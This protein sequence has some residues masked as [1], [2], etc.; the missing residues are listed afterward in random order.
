MPRLNPEDFPEELRE[1]VEAANAEYDQAVEAASRYEG[2]DGDPEVLRRA[3]TMYDQY[4]DPVRAR[5]YR[6]QMARDWGI[7]QEGQSLDDLRALNE[8]VA[9][10]PGEPDPFYADGV[11]PD[12]QAAMQML[13]QRYLSR[14][15][16]EA[17]RKEMKEMM[18][19]AER[20]RRLE[21][22]GMALEAQERDLYRRLQAEGVTLSDTARQ[23][24]QAIAEHRLS[25]G[26]VD[27]NNFHTTIE[28]SYAM[29]QQVVA[30]QAA[31]L[32]RQQAAAPKVTDPASQT[33]GAQREIRGIKDATEVAR[34][35][36]AAMR[37]AGEFD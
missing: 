8:Q 6:E 22:D 10:Y 2:L 33:P 30:E 1:Q 3:K 16:V 11:D 19:A 15:E 24:I 37:A 7:L 26:Q 31:E 28:D 13:D 4:T 5:S 14:Q 23:Q 25:S 27:G 35:R 32:A 21:A 20:E 36:L 9:N 34:E 17:L 18:S 29:F 12:A